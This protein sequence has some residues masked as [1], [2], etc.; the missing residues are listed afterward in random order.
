MNCTLIIPSLLIYSG[1]YLT[2][3][4]CEFITTYRVLKFTEWFAICIRKW[5]SKSIFLKLWVIGYFQST[6]ILREVCY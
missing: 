6:K 3:T 1:Y 2:V 4:Y 5:S